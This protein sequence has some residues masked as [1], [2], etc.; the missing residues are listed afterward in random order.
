MEDNF[1]KGKKIIDSRKNHTQNKNFRTWKS[2]KAWLY[3]SSA[4]ALLLAGGGGLATSVTVKADEVAQVSTTSTTS[5]TPAA[6]TPAVATPTDDSATTQTA[7]PQTAATTSDVSTTAA[8]TTSDSSTTTPAATS[9]TD[10]STDTTAT[11]TTSNSST[12]TPAATSAT[13]ASTATTATTTASDSS[14]TSPAATSATGASTATQAATSATG[15]S[16][17]TQATTSATGASTATQAATSATGASTTT[18]ATTSATSTTS[19]TATVTPKVAVKSLA[20]A[21]P[22]AAQTSLTVNAMPDNTQDALTSASENNTSPT[23]VKVADPLTSAALSSAYAAANTAG[24]L[25]LVSTA[26]QFQTAYNN[27][28]TTYIQLVPNT[29]L[30]LAAA[31]NSRTSNLIIDGNGGVI[32]LGNYNLPLGSTVGHTPQT[33]SVNNVTLNT[34]QTGSDDGQGN[35][36]SVINANAYGGSGDWNINVKD[37]TAGSTGIGLVIA[38]SYSQIT[39]SGKDTFSADTHMVATGTFYVANGAT[40]NYTENGTWSPIY[41]TSTG[42]GGPNK[43]TTGTGAQPNAYFGDGSSIS[44]TTNANGYAAFAGLNNL[45]TGDNVTFN[46]QGSTNFISD[47]AGNNG[48]NPGA[49]YSATGKHTYVFGQYNKISAN[50]SQTGIILNNASDSLTLNHGVTLTLAPTGNAYYAIQNNGTANILSPAAMTLSGGGAYVAITGSGTTNLSNVNVT[51]TPSTNKLNGT[52]STLLTDKNGTWNGY[53]DS[54][55]TVTNVSNTG[56]TSIVMVPGTPGNITINYVDAT[57]ASGKVVGTFTVP[58][59]STSSNLPGDN[60]NTGAPLPGDSLQ[61]IIAAY[62]VNPMPKGYVLATGTE[63]NSTLAAALQSNSTYSGNVS[64]YGINAYDT[65]GQLEYMVVPVTGSTATTHYM[66]V[67]PAPNNSV[68]YNY[69]DAG[70]GAVVAT[71]STQGG[72]EGTGTYSSLPTANVGNNIDFTNSYYTTTNAPAGYH[73]VTSA[74][75]ATIGATQPT[76]VQVTSAA[77]NT[78]LYVLSNTQADTLTAPSAATV[79]AGGSVNLL[80]GVSGTDS[81]LNSF[82]GASASAA[83]TLVVTVDGTTVSPDANGNVSYNPS[84]ATPAGTHNVVYTFTDPFNSAQLTATQVI[85]VT[86]LA[87]PTLSV[88]PSSTI[89]AGDTINY[90]NAPAN[91][92]GTDAYGKT[93]SYSTSSPYITITLSTQVGSAAPT[94]PTTLP[95]G[96]VSVATKASDPTTVYTFNYTYTDP[97]TNVAATAKYV[98]TENT[99][100]APVLTANSTTNISAGGSVNLLTG[101]TGTDSSLN[102]LDFTNAQTLANLQLSVVNSS[103]ITGTI[104]GTTYNSKVTDASGTATVTYKYTDPNSQKTA[105]ATQVINIGKLASPAL[106]VQSQ[107]VS[108]GQTVQLVG[109]PASLA[110][111]D[112][113]GNAI[114]F[115]Q[116][117]QIG[118]LAISVTNNRTSVTSA[119]PSGTTSFVTSVKDPNTTYTV[120]YVYTDPTTGYTGKATSTVTENALAA[121]VLNVLKSNTVTAGTNYELVANP[122]NLAGTDATGTAIDFILPSQLANLAITMDGTAVTGTQY[123]FAANATSGQHVVNYIYTDPTTGVKATAQQLITLSALAQPELSVTASQTINA[124][125]SVQLVGSPSSLTGTDSEGNTINFADA[126]QLANLT[127]TIDGKALPTGTTVL[128]TNVKDGNAT[129]TVNYTYIDPTTGFS[130]GTTQI[131]NEVAL[132]APTLSVAPSQNVTAGQ[133]VQ[134]VN[135]P[136]GLTGTDANG[137]TINFSNSQQLANLKFL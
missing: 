65:T 10:A 105:T 121:P 104:S 85:T 9:A 25:A 41:F 115:T 116:A 134:L 64:L 122:S 125:Q 136:A 79:V 87:T 101:L 93:I 112:S 131:I 56:L 113:N 94:N 45:T 51:T 98:V 7:A 68:T 58:V 84:T 135:S 11:A 3:S 78:T 8:T 91:L 40:V 119:L 95:A 126:K 82:T 76:T 90:I 43:T 27:A 53:L 29:T 38:A 2:K 111:T 46:V 127:I 67:Y 61:A 57:S 110:G 83:K 103:G 130:T 13:D 39:L 24:T 4:L 80:T 6:A 118:N 5:A 75:N 49:N 97:A 22:T 50:T 42:T 18:P 100:A 59:S 16:T 28:A 102:S 12:T 32:N 66:M 117:A 19:T 99:L 129:H 74:Q 107:T 62:A 124:G 15:A 123:Q 31:L 114:D 23:T 63:V 128:A 36:S 69:V 72:L 21:V 73:Y 26:A 34:T 70:T 47:A 132:A 71:G 30:T 133:T 88:T 109:S 48:S 33:F 44:I 1:S 17:V 96:Q 106:N 52:V 81:N 54:T 35:N 14:T 86:P 20:A 89:N 137:Q 37:T 120:N 55:Q 92:T 60:L 77:S 108:A